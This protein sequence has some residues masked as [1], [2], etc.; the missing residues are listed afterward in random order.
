[1]DEWQTESN[2]AAGIRLKQHTTF[3]ERVAAAQLCADRLG[4]QIPTL[5]DGMD[6]AAAEAFSAW[7]ERIYIVNQ[8]GRIHF[9]GG[10]GPYEFD[11]QAARVSLMALLARKIASER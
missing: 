2:E 1:M 4:L 7:P 6:N 10:P 5:I 8:A 3:A 11:P 9:R